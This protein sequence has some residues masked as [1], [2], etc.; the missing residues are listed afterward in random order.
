MFEEVVREAG[1]Q[2]AA[3]YIDDNLAAGRDW[4]F[5]VTEIGPPT[6]VMAATGDT[7]FNNFSARWL[8]DHIPGAELLWRP[9]GHVGAG[10]KEE[11]DLFAWLGHGSF[12]DPQPAG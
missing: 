10:G 2:G 8:A 6:K 9:G 7:A 4:G 11:Q 1:R 12:P 5:S 3:G